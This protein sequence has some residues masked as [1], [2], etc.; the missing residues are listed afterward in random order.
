LPVGGDLLEQPW[1]G[2]EDCAPGGRD[3]RP[4]GW[5]FVDQRWRG[6]LF[7]QTRESAE[8]ERCDPPALLVEPLAGE[9]AAGDDAGDVVGQQDRD[10]RHRV[11]GF[12]SAHDVAKL[13][14]SLPTV[15]RGHHSPLTVIEEQP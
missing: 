6:D 10:S 9:V 3:D 5:S 12:G 8:F 15:G 11:V 13:F 7:G 14:K 1:V 2:V 4:G